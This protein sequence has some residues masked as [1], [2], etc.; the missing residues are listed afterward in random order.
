MTLLPRNNKTYF[1]LVSMFSLTVLCIG[2]RFVFSI[3]MQ[4]R[5]CIYPTMDIQ[6]CLSCLIMP[7]LSISGIVLIGEIGGTAEE[8]AAAFIKVSSWCL[9]Y[10]MIIIFYAITLLL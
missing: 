5:K 1:P 2:S 6:L 4:F 8:D 9:L 10:G 3:N 7:A